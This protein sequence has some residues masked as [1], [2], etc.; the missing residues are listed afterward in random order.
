MIH[1][2]IGVKRQ[3][4]FDEDASNYPNDVSSRHPKLASGK[5]IAY[6][7]RKVM[8]KNA[9]K[10]WAVSKRRAFGGIC[11]A[12]CLCMS[13]PARADET[14]LRT[15]TS[16]HRFIPDEP[17][18]DPDQPALRYALHGGRWKSMAGGSVMLVGVDSDSLRIGL[19]LAGFLELINFTSGDPVPWQSY[20]ANI[21]AE[22]NAESP[23]FSRALLPSG[24][25]L[26][27]SV[28]WFH[29]SDHA[30]AIS[31]YEA[32]YLK[33]HEFGALGGYLDNANFSA[34]EYIKIRAGYRQSLW[35]DK[36][37]TRLTIGTRIFPEP[38]NP[39]SIRALRAAFLVDARVSVCIRPS[40]RP[41]L[42]VYHE[43]VTN[44]FVAD[45]HGF[46][47]GLDHTP[48]RYSILNLGVDFV[49]A[50]GTIM[51]PYVAYSN[52]HGRGIDF[53]KFHGSEIGFGL[54][55]LL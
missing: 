42:S 7:R 22:I 24:G 17:R 6:A 49:G 47:F 46:Q 8:P 50:S 5:K 9:K 2:A 30:A 14:H 29:E 55:W 33:P 25:H 13:T 40:I 35:G 44:D 32:Q 10:Q 26:Y 21:G 20:R 48:L 43:I 18:A 41:F 53:P 36:L 11:A 28:G 19:S 31:I 38:I 52:S 39:G 51:S 4:D 12:V 54:M 34:Y 37:R 16:T 1:H 23:R 27:L 45:A 15:L 3:H